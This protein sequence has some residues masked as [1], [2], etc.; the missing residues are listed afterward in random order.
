M[1]SED[2]EAA[3]EA[4]LLVVMHLVQVLL[5]HRLGFHDFVLYQYHLHVLVFLSFSTHY[6]RFVY[7]LVCLQA[8]VLVFLG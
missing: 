7:F 8:V 3:L 2:L 4:I 5:Y 1:T 6:Q